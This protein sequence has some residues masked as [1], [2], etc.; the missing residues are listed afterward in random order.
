MGKQVGG[1]KPQTVCI[2]YPP[3]VNETIVME[4]K[5]PIYGILRSLLNSKAIKKERYQMMR[6]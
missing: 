3:Q 2:S 6:I 5:T 4:F 1:D